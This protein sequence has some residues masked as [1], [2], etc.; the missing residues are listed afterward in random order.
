MRVNFTHVLPDIFSDVLPDVLPDMLP[1]VIPD[2]PPD[3]LSDI[4]PT[5]IFRCSQKQDFTVA[6]KNHRTRGL[7]VKYKQ[8]HGPQRDFVP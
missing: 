7:E 4:L 8:S 6:I 2:V 5:K 1:D 3:V